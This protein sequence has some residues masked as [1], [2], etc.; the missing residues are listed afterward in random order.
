MKCVYEMNKT[1]KCF[2]LLE[3]NE[4]RRMIRL[5]SLII[6]KKRLN[7]IWITAGNVSAF[8]G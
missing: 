8:V 2:F 5:D 7:S 3:G 4:E 1:K 6:N